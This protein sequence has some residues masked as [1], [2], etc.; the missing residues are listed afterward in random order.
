M[1]GYVNGSGGTQ[2]ARPTDFGQLASEI[3]IHEPSMRYE[4]RVGGAPVVPDDFRS[5][6]CQSQHGNTVLCI[7]V[8]PI[9]IRGRKGTDR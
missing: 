7:Y 2:I 8:V 1:R 6:H 3:H 4:Q 5:A 9:C